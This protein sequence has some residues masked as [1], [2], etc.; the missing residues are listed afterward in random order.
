MD[1]RQ[2]SDRYAVS[3]QITPEDLPAAKA[4]GFARVICN[5][6]DAENPPELQADVMAQAAAAAGLAFEVLPITHASMTPD[7]VTRQRDLIEGAEGPVLAYCASGTRCTVIWALGEVA[8][9][10]APQDV[11]GDAGR[12]GYDLS[13]L[14][15]TL[16]AIAVQRGT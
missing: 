2:L 12:A 13:N 3:P 7:T 10:R 4:A 14:A 16:Q 5:R 6:P 8:A 9:G 15:P 1:I 11:I